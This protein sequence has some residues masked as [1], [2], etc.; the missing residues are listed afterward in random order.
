MAAISSTVNSASTKQPVLVEPNQNLSAASAAAAVGQKALADSEKNQKMPAQKLDAEV[1]PLTLKDVGTKVA[2]VMQEIARDNFNRMQG[3]AKD[4]K[5]LSSG[6]FYP[7]AYA[8]AL[9][10]ADSK[11]KDEMIAKGKKVPEKTSLMERFEWLKKKDHF[12]KGFAPKGF[13][14]LTVPN[15]ASGSYPC[16]LYA[17]KGLK[18]SEALEALQKGLSLLGCDTVIELSIYKV[19][20]DILTKDKFDAL[21]A[22]GEST[23]FFIG[24]KNPRNPIFLLYTEKIPGDDIRNAEVGD[25]V[26]FQNIDAYKI[27]HVNGEAGGFNVICSVAGLVPKFLGLGISP[28]GSTQ[29][30]ITETLLKEYN[31]DP[32]DDSVFFSPEIIAATAEKDSPTL[33]THQL[34]TNTF[35]KKGGGKMVSNGRLNIKRLIQLR[36]AS[37]AEGKLLLKK[38]GDEKEKKVEQ[39]LIYAVQ[40]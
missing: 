20:Q 18:P 9:L 14:H 17:E 31:R 7:G 36:D 40:K 22:F 15:F 8:E 26:H 12:Y 32:F 10:D 11:F 1:K 34:T 16:H 27:K 4:I 30:E 33:K 2:A 13:K 28:E 35:K 21:F 6:I 3:Y 24:N 25:F 37:I 23:Q 38:W 29:R 39:S 5:L 19:L